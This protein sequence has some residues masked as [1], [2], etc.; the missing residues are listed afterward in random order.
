MQYFIFVKEGVP[1]IG[2]MP[3]G[4]TAQEVAER[5][6]VTDP[7][8]YSSFDSS[9]FDAACFSFPQ[10]FILSGG[11]VSFSLT[12]AKTLAV[13]QEKFKFA[14]LESTAT[15]G[16]SPNQLSSQAS[17]PAVDR[18]PE[19]QAVLDAVNVLAV[20]LS[21][22][23]TAIEAATDIETVYNIVQQPSG[24]INTGR[25][26][27]GQ[28]GPL[29]LNLS[30]F[31]E[32]S[33]MPGYTQADLELYVPG[34]NT[35]IPYNSNLPDPFTFDSA[36]NCFNNGD[37]RLV[38]RYAGGGAVLSTITVPQGNNVDVPWTYNPNIPPLSSSSSSQK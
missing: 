23:L 19:I 32:L 15:A 18:L 29:D 16:F 11:V 5:S 13:N 22:N 8:F 37:W 1:Q 12:E 21:A 7:S 9:S 33:N 14:G 27:Q 31:T 6:G 38:I 20:E 35:V 28:A 36:G 17:L 30:Y 25:G 3:E 2:I 4:Q 34:T 24:I 26:G 10:A